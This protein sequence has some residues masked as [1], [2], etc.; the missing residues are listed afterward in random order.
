MRKGT[1][2]FYYPEDAQETIE[3]YHQRYKVTKNPL[4]LM[5]AFCTAFGGGLGQDFPEWVLQR[6]YDAFQAYLEGPHQKGKEDVSFDVLLKCKRGKGQ[7]TIKAE[8]AQRGRDLIL[9]TS[10]DILLRYSTL[11][12]QDAAG[13]VVNHH[14]SLSPPSEITVAKRYY[15]EKWKEQ[16]SKIRM[17]P[18]RDIKALLDLVPKEFRK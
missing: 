15:D 10:I 11:N 5:R 6:L 14:R 7:A 17:Y 9:M 2:G 16:L 3:L 12:V 18:E 1:T 4:E 8:A 13:I